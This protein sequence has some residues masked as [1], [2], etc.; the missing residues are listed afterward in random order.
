MLLL[1]TSCAAGPDDAR[2]RW[3]PGEGRCRRSESRYC[4]ADT[5]FIGP[6]YHHTPAR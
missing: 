4:S 3:L 2:P 6:F 1:L 5:R